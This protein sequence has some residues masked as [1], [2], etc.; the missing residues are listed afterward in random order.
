MQTELLDTSKWK[1]RVEL[2]TTT[3]DWTEV[4][5]NPNRRN[6]SPMEPE[7]RH[8]HNLPPP[9]SHKH[10]PKSGAHITRTHNR[11]PLKATQSS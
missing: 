11:V 7:Q 9:D 10:S 1:T 4:F 8:Q 6:I 2:S 5:Y 3:F